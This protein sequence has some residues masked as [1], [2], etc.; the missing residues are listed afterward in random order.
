MKGSI[1]LNAQ[2]KL[3]FIAHNRLAVGVQFTITHTTL[4][5]MLN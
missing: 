3:I 2:F 5:A 4:L 1:I